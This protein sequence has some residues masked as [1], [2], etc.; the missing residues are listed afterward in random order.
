[1]RPSTGIFFHL[2]ESYKQNKAIFAMIGKIQQPV[3]HDGENMRFKKK[4]PYRL[5]CTLLQLT[6]ASYGHLKLKKSC[7]ILKTNMKVWIQ[8]SVT[9]PFQ[10][11]HKKLTNFMTSLTETFPCVCLCRSFSNRTHAITKNEKKTHRKE[12]RLCFYGYGVI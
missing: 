9:K 5:F 8:S 10:L 3:L 1:M 7:S 11:L 4:A 6:C 12:K 2:Y